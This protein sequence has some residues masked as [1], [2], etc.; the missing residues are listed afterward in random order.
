MLQ[1]RSVFVVDDDPSI[2]SSVNRLLRAHGFAAT[3]FESA[4]ALLDHDSFDKAICIVLDINLDGKSGI[5]LRRQLAEEGVT[6]PVIY[7][8]GNDSAANRSAAMASGCVA[9]LI[10]PFTAKSLIESVGRASA[11]A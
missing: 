2:R 6:T 4:S 10:K 9:Y 7:I 8:T 3:L 11:A 1:P 5:D